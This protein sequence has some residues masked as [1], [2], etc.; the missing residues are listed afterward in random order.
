MDFPTRVPHLGTKDTATLV[1]FRSTSSPHKLADSRVK[2]LQIL[3]GCG[4]I[5]AGYFFGFKIPVFLKQEAAV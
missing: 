2:V 4:Q 1:E 3:E 5:H